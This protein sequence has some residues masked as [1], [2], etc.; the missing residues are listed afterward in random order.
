MATVIESLMKYEARSYSPSGH[1][2]STI[3]R[4]FPPLRG[5]TEKN[6][7]RYVISGNWVNLGK[8]S[9]SKALLGKLAENRDFAN[10]IMDLAKLSQ[11]NP[12]LAKMDRKTIKAMAKLLQTAN[13][14]AGKRKYISEQ[15]FNANRKILGNLTQWLS[16]PQLTGN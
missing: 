4:M 11:D 3:A 15:R 12:D 9:R 13:K 2:T 14:V 8:T 1:L 7:D 16:T 6:G 10:P 5:I